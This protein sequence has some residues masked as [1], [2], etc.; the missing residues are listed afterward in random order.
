MERHELIRG[1]TESS[2]PADSQMLSAG[3]GE[4][5]LICEAADTNL[6][7]FLLI[8]GPEITFTNR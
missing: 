3:R 8:Y 4:C 7:T 1:P 6:E 5:G 2:E